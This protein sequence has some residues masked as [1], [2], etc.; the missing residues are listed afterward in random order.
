MSLFPRFVSHEM[1]PLLRLFEDPL[2]NPA[3]T[4]QQYRRTIFQPN[5]DVRETKDA[6]LLDGEVPG[7]SDKNALDIKFV[8]PSTLVVKGKIERSKSFG[9][10]NESVPVDTEQA[11]Q[12]AT[13]D[14]GTESSL[15]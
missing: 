12:K 10:D 1:R 11:G 14:E 5:F 2:F 7:I 8:D 9:P 3:S 13:G 6:Y 15:T 4:L